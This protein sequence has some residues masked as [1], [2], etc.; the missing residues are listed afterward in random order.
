MLTPKFCSDNVFSEKER[1][2]LKEM[3]QRLDEACQ[4]CDNC[5]ACIFSHFCNEGNESPSEQ[6]AKIISIL[7]VN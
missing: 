1:I 2:F 4:E 3:I 6:L 5:E 7:G